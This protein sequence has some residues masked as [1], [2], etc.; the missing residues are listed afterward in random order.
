MEGDTNT[1]ANPNETILIPLLHKRV[2]ELTSENI[3]L[4]ARLQWTEQEKSE[5]LAEVGSKTQRILDLENSEGGKI[6]SAQAAVRAECEREKAAAVE[7]ATA[8]MRAVLERTT[9]ELRST[10]ERA[11]QERAA[12]RNITE[13]EKRT[14]VENWQRELDTQTGSLKAQIQALTEQLNG[15]NA[16][17]GSLQA[18][19]EAAKPAAEPPKPEPK[20]K[21]KK[22]AAVTMG[23]GTF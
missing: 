3:L 17:I 16:T 7:K 21:G 2:G 6:E 18:L 11:E 1:K 22:D 15:A 13:A 14:V 5:M 8:E 20:R 10:A 4:Q 12:L 9:A 19:V 23:G